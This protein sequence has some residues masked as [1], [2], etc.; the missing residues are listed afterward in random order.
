MNGR[1][2]S[3]TTTVRPSAANSRTASPIRAP[4]TGLTPPIGSS[5]MI[6][7]GS[8]AAMR[9]NSSSRFWPP[10]SRTA[11]SFLS[12]A[13]LKRSRMARTVARSA[14]SSRRIRR[15]RTIERQRDS[16]ANRRRAS[17]TLSMTVRLRHSRGV[18]NVRISPSREMTSGRL[19]MIGSP[20]NLTLPESGRPNPLARS[21][22]VLLPAPFGPINPVT[23]PSGTEKV[24]LRTAWTPPKD[25]VRLSISSSALI[26]CPLL[27]LFFPLASGPPPTSPFPLHWRLLP[28][29]L[30]RRS[31]V[32]AAPRAFGSRGSGRHSL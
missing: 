15:A 13:R 8:A 25:L 6:S 16:S 12:P 29:S 5:R 18:W 4:S 30:L 21:T 3:T 32:Q 11:R 23:W 24:Q 14:S 22:T 27:A 20:A 7:R 9:A 10:L 26:L 19:P 1:L 17:R 2:C 28:S 31:S